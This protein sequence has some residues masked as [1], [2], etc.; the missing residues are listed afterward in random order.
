MKWLHFAVVALLVGAGLA[1]AWLSAELWSGATKLELLQFTLNFF[2]V[3]G[4]GTLVS[5]VVRHAQERRQKEDAN[6][7]LVRG[8]LEECVRAYASTKKAR[9][10]LRARAEV[11]TIVG[12]SIVPVAPGGIVSTEAFDLQME[13]IIDAQ[14]A[15][16]LLK[17]RVKAHEPLFAAPQE[18]GD[19]FGALDGYLGRLIREYELLSRSVRMGKPLAGEDIPHLRDLLGR[20]DATKF[21]SEFVATYRVAIDLLERDSQVGGTARKGI[22]A[23]VRP[24]P[25]GPA[26]ETSRQAA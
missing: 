23:G 19:A 9:R 11:V 6:R 18:L 5:F 16:E 10:L 2:G 24:A 8:L 1:A 7:Q 12:D 25:P 13:A 22:V 14:L 15:F 17:R 26:D 4:L 21:Q 20:E 3:V